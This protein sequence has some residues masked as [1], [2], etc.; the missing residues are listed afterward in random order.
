M[1][2]NHGKTTREKH[3]ELVRRMCGL[4]AEAVADADCDIKLNRHGTIRFYKQ[5]SDFLGKR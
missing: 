4:T 2:L 5:I 3:N 1:P